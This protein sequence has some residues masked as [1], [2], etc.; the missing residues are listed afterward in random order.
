MLIYLACHKR[1]YSKRHIIKL[2]L[3]W[4]SININ[5]WINTKHMYG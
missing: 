3:T 5:G 4:K 1:Y 2:D